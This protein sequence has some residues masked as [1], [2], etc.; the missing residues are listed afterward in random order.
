MILWKVM[1]T[2][3]GKTELIKGRLTLEEARKLRTEHEGTVDKT[4][5]SQDP[6]DDDG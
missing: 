6:M 1:L 5:I 3:R 2:H 4:W